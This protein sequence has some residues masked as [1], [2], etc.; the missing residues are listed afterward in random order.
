M[1]SI[2]KV[3]GYLQLLMVQCY[4]LKRLMKLPQTFKQKNSYLQ[5]N[6]IE[7]KMKF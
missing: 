2:F 3:L 5:L 7:W 1:N 4:V 6:I